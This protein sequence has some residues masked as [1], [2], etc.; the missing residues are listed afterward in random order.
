MRERREGGRAEGAKQRG[1]AASATVG[2]GVR[3]LEISN[4][5]IRSH[6]FVFPKAVEWQGQEEEEN[7]SDDDI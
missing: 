2:Y 3:F 1:R 4:P 7:E 5:L 6:R